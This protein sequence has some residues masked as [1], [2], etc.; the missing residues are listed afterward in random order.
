M[1][2]NFCN[3]Q[4]CFLICYGNVVREGLTG[5]TNLGFWLKFRAPLAASLDF[6][7]FSWREYSI[8]KNY[9]AEIDPTLN[10]PIC[11]TSPAQQYRNLCWR[12]WYCVFAIHYSQL[13]RMH[14]IFPNC[15]IS[16][17]NLI[18]KYRTIN[19]KCSTWI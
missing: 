3:Q 13:N 6:F 7:R 5:L 4:G 2:N 1:F 18:S 8:Q 12:I 10:W 16:H 17:N 15:K 19:K 14:K 9:L 11:P